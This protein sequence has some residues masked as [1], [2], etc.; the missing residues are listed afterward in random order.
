MSVAKNA[1]GKYVLVRSV[2]EGV[3][4]GL[5]VDADGTGVI[6]KG[7]RR[8]WDHASK[9]S[10]LEWYEGVSVS[11]LSDDSEISCAVLEKVIIEDY[12]LTICSEACIASITNFK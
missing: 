11:G 7:A 10:D 5:V 8:L 1:I 2:N 12:S 4:F 6:I 3:N 9:D